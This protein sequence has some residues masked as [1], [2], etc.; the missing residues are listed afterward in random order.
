MSIIIIFCMYIY[1]CLPTFQI[2]KTVKIV[3]IAKSVLDV[4]IAKI[5]YVHQYVNHAMDVLH[6]KIVM[7]V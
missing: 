4:K 6:Q 5:A 7:T 1:L 2:M 3:L